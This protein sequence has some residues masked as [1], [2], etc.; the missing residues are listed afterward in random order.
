MTAVPLVLLALLCAGGL[1]RGWALLGAVVALMAAVAA[2]ASPSQNA[3]AVRKR[4]RGERQ[5]MLRSQRFHS[6][7]PRL[8][9]PAA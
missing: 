2:D 3:D 8:T 1:P 4:V 7:A 6:D 9:S 5:L